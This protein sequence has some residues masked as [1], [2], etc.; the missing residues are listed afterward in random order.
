MVS[1]VVMVVL[2]RSGGRQSRGWR[3]VNALFGLAF[4][5]YGVYLAFV[6]QGGTYFIFVKAFILPLLLVVNFF[7]SLAARRRGVGQPG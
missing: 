7:R 4:A 1:G 5:G 3:V 2:A 6:F